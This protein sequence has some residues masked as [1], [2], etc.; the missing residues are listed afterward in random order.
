MVV[1][2]NV[3]YRKYNSHLIHLFAWIYGCM[4]PLDGAC[5]CEIDAY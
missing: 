3:K 4:F 5:Y 2:C 1:K